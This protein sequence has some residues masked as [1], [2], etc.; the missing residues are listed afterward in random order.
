M[1]LKLTLLLIASIL[2]MMLAGGSASAYIGYL[3]GREALKVVTQPDINSERS[4][5]KKKPLG[6]P[7]K[8]LKIIKE[9]EILIN[10]YNYMEAKKKRSSFTEQSLSSSLVE[11]VDLESEPNSVDPQNFPIS[12]NSGG[13]TFEVSQAQREGSSLTLNVN[14]RNEGMKSVKFL[15]SFLDVRDDRG[16][17]L[18]AI[19]DGLPGELPANGENFSGKLRIPVSLLDKSQNISLTLTDYPEQKLQLKLEKI[20]VTR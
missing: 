16:R 10:V 9:R 11:P 12:H 5:D 2:L 3:M 4:L 20:P 13:V 18:S 19:A 17:P 8:G 14:M 1:N 15:Y 6:G 7:Y